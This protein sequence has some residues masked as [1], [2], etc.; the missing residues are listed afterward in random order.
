MLEETLGYEANT[1]FSVTDMTCSTVL[2]K[3]TLP[4]KQKPR[5]TTVK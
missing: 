3:A 5:S 2:V 4:I 1:F